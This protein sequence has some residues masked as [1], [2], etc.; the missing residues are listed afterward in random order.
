[1]SH[2][3]GDKFR[4]SHFAGLADA[5]LKK[6]LE[7]SSLFHDVE[8]DIVYDR[9]LMGP[10]NCLNGA[11]PTPDILARIKHHTPNT[12]F[13]KSADWIDRLERLNEV[14]LV[15][16]NMVLLEENAQY[17]ST[18][19]ILEDFLCIG[20]NLPRDSYATEFRNYTLDI[21]EQVTKYWEFSPDQPLYQSLLS[22]VNNKDRGVVLGALLCLNRGS[23]ELECNN[24]LTGVPIKTVSCI[25]DYTLVDDEE[26]LGV[27]LD[28]LYQYTAIPENVEEILG[29]LRIDFDLV[30]RLVSL[31]MH[32]AEERVIMLAPRVAPAK[33]EP[34]EIPDQFDPELI[35][36]I[37]TNFTEPERSTRW[38]LCCF[39]ENEEQ[40]VTQIQLWQSYQKCFGPYGGA[41][42][43]LQ[44]SEFIKKVSGTFNNANA[45]VIN[46]TPPRFIIKGIQPR[47]RPLD[48]QGRTIE[49]CLWI[50]EN[51]GQKKPCNRHFFSEE[52]GFNH[53]AKDHLNL[54]EKDKSK[55]M[56]REEEGATYACL[57]NGCTRFKKSDPNVRVILSHVVNHIKKPEVSTN[58]VKD[59]LANRGKTRKYM[60]T[61]QDE[62]RNPTGLPLTS[63]LILKNLAR[64]VSKME[65]GDEVMEKLFINVKDQLGHVWAMNMT[66][67]KDMG[68]LMMM[69]VGMTKR[70]N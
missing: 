18:F 51:D 61:Q 38:L 49:T 29:K 5:L 66:L 35:N 31:L 25:I 34:A 2:E 42:P 16:R 65:K 68:D 43:L 9:T 53:I 58:P 26:F 3:R 60:C 4:F 27:C 57:W 50:E 17:L 48:L 63:V 6:A 7:I 33:P 44:A 64:H 30:P 28:F 46:S 20:L 11:D 54:P 52:E 22:L 70:R 62:R 14:G 15:I 21:A 55:F 45:Q 13:I 40:E 1:V 39:E 36:E 56:A 12:Q 47:R 19:P 67:A 37:G 10:P 23:T 41:N 24:N 69:I 32:R 59:D 8:W